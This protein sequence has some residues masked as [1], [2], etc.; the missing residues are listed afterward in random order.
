[1]ISFG[2]KTGMNSFRNDF[3]SN[4]LKIIVPPKKTETD[5]VLILS[6]PTYT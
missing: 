5:I 3:Y 2:M 1:M 6:K 4:V